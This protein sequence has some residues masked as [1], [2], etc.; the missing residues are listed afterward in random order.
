[1]RTPKRCQNRVIERLHTKRKTGH[2][3]GEQVLHHSLSE[4]LGIHLERAL[5][6]RGKVHR[7]R[8]RIE[9]ARELLVTDMGRRPSADIDRFKIPEQI[10]ARSCANR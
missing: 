5:H 4:A 6:L 2:T 7:E 10:G 3:K 9:Q 1:M 8:E